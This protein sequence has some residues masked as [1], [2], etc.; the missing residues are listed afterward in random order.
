MAPRPGLEPGSQ[1]RQAWMIGRATPPRLLAVF[2]ERSFLTLW[3]FLRISCRGL[4]PL[5]LVLSWLEAMGG[6]LSLAEVCRTFMI[7][8]TRY[9][10]TEYERRLLNFLDEGKKAKYLE[11]LERLRDG[12]N[13]LV[14]LSWRAWSLWR[15][16]GLSTSSRRGL[17]ECWLKTACFPVAKSL[18]GG[19]LFLSSIGFLYTV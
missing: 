9:V 17:S 19:S 14:R 6:G 4:S 7:S 5:L 2:S 10:H 11:L 3:G 12:D 15:T 8:T 13:P 1:A 18:D 16:I